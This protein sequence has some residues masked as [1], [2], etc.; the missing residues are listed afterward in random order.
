[1]LKIID[2]CVM[3]HSK[4][5]IAHPKTPQSMLLDKKVIQINHHSHLNL[6]F[7][8]LFAKIASPVKQIFTSKLVNQWFYQ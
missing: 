3:H 1:M 5:M 7:L 8:T 2:N 4:E 6:P